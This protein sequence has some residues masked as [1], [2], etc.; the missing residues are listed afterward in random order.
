MDQGALRRELRLNVAAAGI[1]ALGA[2]MAYLFRSG[3]T[4]LQNLLFF[5]ALDPLA[6]PL[7]Q[8]GLGI[9]VVALPVLGAIGG[10][11]IL[12]LLTGR[13]EGG[14][15][16]AVIEAASLRGGR[17]SMPASLAQGLGA[18][19]TLGAGG[20]AGRE[21]PI[22]VLGGATG[23]SIAESLGLERKDRRILIA[24]G[25]T[26]GI[27]ATFNAPI[28]AVAFAIE[29]IF[30]EFRT[31]SFVPIVVA[32]VFG[33]AV[34]RILLGDTPTFDLAPGRFA[35][36]SPFELLL[37]IGLGLAAGLFGFAFLELSEG[38]D[39][40]FDDRP[41]WSRPL[42]GG[43]AMGL[44]GL[45]LPRLLGVGYDTMQAVLDGTLGAPLLGS[46]A[47]TFALLL[48]LKPIAVALTLGGGG[49]GGVFSPTLYAGIMLGGLFGLAAGAVMP[50]LTSGYQV[51]AVL[52]MVAVF[53]AVSRAAL[54]GIVLSLEFTHTFEIV[55]PAMLAAVIADVV[56]WSLHRE[57][58][59]HTRLEEKG[60]HLPH[61]L[62]PNVLDVVL[63]E[64]TMSR[65]VET[66]RADET[67]RE[68]L[69]RMIQTGHG[70]FPVVDDEG[71]LVGV[72][73]RTDLRERPGDVPLEAPVD[74][75]MTADVV[76]ALP[77]ETVHRVLDRMVDRGIGNMPVVD[78]DDPTELVGWMTKT[79]VIEAET[80][81]QEDGWDSEPT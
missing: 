42:I 36:T 53:T 1:G 62:A 10:I 31:E 17:L 57:G 9:W 12:Y 81:D 72:V 29:A 15:T 60:I 16:V 77:D 68:V 8:H 37:V 80:A 28:A 76:V 25:A 30:L 71:D 65:E 22:A 2:L 50:S 35:L 78:P 6:R 7:F 73:T 51:Y 59:L 74:R 43:A 13:T 61:D 46:L 3:V 44:L 32:S 4:V 45:A 26:G 55:V 21:G 79:D 20:S 38:A 41:L 23:S 63:V 24:C 33:T 70:G 19:V 48:V 69:D 34:G 18:I 11:A 40:W 64:E 75:L 39:R 54:T 56:A 49:S 5:Q 58:L 66:V 67:I 27:A 47:L 14:S 52:G